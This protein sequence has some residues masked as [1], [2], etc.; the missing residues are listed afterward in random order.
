MASIASICNVALG[1]IGEES[2]GLITEDTPGATACNVFW[3]TSRDA[4]LAGMHWSFCTKR[5]ELSQSS[6]TPDFGWSYQYPLPSDLLE[7][8]TINEGTEAQWAIEEANLLTNESE[9]E[10]LYSAKITDVAKWSALFID[11]F[12]TRLA[13]DIV[14][15][16]KRDFG[17]QQKL[18]QLFDYKLSK[19][20][21]WDSSRR[22]DVQQY[23]Q[24][25]D[26][27]PWLNART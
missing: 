26:N 23:D 4:T 11:A 15:R 12:A 19:A 6:T 24:D 17:L 14:P 9:V 27:Y 22:Y 5:V 3:E 8:I 18:M 16:V 10:L 25:P 21:S 20:Q 2:I 13:A 7:P 1:M